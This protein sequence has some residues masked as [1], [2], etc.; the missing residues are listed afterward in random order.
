MDALRGGA[1]L[2]L[3]LQHATEYAREVSEVPL[4]LTMLSQA[5]Q[6]FRM[7]VLMLL[8]GML[9]ERSL[10]KPLGDYY[11]GKFQHALWPYLVWHAVDLHFHFGFPLSDVRAWWGWTY[12]WFLFY[13]ILFYVVA[14]AF[15]RLPSWVPVCLAL[16]AAVAID[17]A[18]FDPSPL[19]RPDRLAYYA[20]FF[21]SGYWAAP[22]IARAV[23][24][25]SELRHGTFTGLVVVGVVAN[26]SLA[27]NLT[28][29]VWAI[30]LVLAGALAAAGL[31]ARLC[32]HH[33]SARIRFIGMRSLVYYVVH[34]PLILLVLEFLPDQTLS[35]LMAVPVLLVAC[36]A[37]IT[38]LAALS[39]RWPVSWLFAAPWPSTRRAARPPT[40]AGGSRAT[41]DP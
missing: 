26:A 30:P 16:A 11:R 38:P 9:L 7:P 28:E 12:L 4:W 5:A 6:P 33:P 37:A 13:I 8:S 25:V 35:G 14:P 10:A 24:L 18:P 15:R 1:I 31:V 19:W 41:R 3:L 27:I 32:A 36:L 21:F 20:V 29:K 17:L 23:A 2:L 40:H 34:V 22:R 39:H